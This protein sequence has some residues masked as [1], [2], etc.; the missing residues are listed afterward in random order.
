MSLGSVLIGLVIVVLAFLIY[1]SS[2]NIDPQNKACA[3]AIARL[4]QNEQTA[5]VPAVHDLLREHQRT[6]EQAR[7][8]SKLVA[9]K[10]R[11]SGAYQDERLHGMKLVREAL[12][13]YKYKPDASTD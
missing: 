13:S 4:I 10:L 7:E 6:E 1:H 12:A 5:T 11:N 2:R 9:P 3:E 8:V